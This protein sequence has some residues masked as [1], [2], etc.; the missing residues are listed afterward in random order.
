MHG[1]V[2]QGTGAPLGEAA[3]QPAGIWGPP[4]APPPPAGNA[5][6][7]TPARQEA[8]SPAT[9]VAGST[10]LAAAAA[11]AC[12]HDPAAVLSI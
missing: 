6:H 5:V 2:P 10:V 9:P 4:V 11:Q 8:Q 7:A 12:F 1:W 3:R